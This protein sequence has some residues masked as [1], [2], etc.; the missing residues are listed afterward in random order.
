MQVIPWSRSDTNYVKSSSEKLDASKTVFVGALHG[1]MHAAALAKVFNDLFD[2]VIYV[3]ID[4]DKHCY[5]IGSCRITFSSRQSYLKAINA[6]FI[7]IKTSGFGKVVQCDPYLEEAP[8]S[9][10]NVQQGPYF[11]RNP[12]IKTSHS[13]I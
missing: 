6:G 1:M 5:P 8:C 9:S 2:N 4:T 12:V 13:I 3:G 10:C 7:E 11:C